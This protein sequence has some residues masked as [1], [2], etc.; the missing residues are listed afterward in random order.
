LRLITGL[1]N[2]GPEYVNTR[3][4]LG[5][6]VIDFLADELRAGSP[7]QK[8]EGGF[9]GPLFING[10]KVCLLKPYTY[11]NN[12]GRSISA[13]AA[14]YKIEVKDILIV[15]DDI[16]LPL[17]RLRLRLRG[18]AGGHNGLKSIIAHLSTLDF[19][20]LRI[21][22]GACPQHYDMADWVLGHFSAAERRVA[23]IAVHKAAQFCQEWCALD[24]EKLMNRVNSSNVNSH[25]GEA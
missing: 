25:D 18:S 4:N 1:G 22:A 23:D 10:E 15:V 16:N 20:R 24:I 6:D 8:F 11:M 13:L 19:A 17:G 21:G 3:H 9:W 5:W 12:S 14:F 2:P 7:S